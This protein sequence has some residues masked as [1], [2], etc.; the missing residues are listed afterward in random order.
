MLQFA[1][2]LA[3]GTV[4]LAIGSANTIYQLPPLVLL[5]PACLYLIGIQAETGAV[6]F[7]KGLIAGMAAF[8]ACLYWIA[9]PFAE[10]TSMPTYLAVSGP[11]GVSFAL[12]F[13]SAA[14]S[15]FCNKFLRNAPP[16]YV[17]MSTFFIWGA[18]ELARGILLSGF[19]W[20]SLA[21]AFSEWPAFV[22]PVSVLGAEGYSAL[23]VALACYITAAM[24][25]SSVKHSVAA[26]VSLALLFTASYC[27]WIQPAD[28][29]AN[30][31]I[32][33]VQG[34]INQG[35]KWDKRFVRGTVERYVTL[36]EKVFDHPVDLV[37]WPETSMPFY[38]QSHPDYLP[39][40]RRL[41]IASKAPYLIGTPG[42]AKGTEGRK[43]DIFNR[44]Y[45]ID[46]EGLMLSWYDKMHLVPFGEYVPFYIPF[47][48]ELLRGTGTF[49]RGTVY[50]PITTGNLAMGVL[51]C[52]EAI[53]TEL[54]QDRVESGAN[55][56]I[57]L[58]NDAW[59][60]K[61]AAPKQHLDMTVLRAVEQGRY[62]AR[63]T[64]TG[65]T[66]II[67]PK[68]N[69]TTKGKSFRADVIF[70]FVGTRTDFTFYHRFF[71]LIR[72]LIVAGAIAVLAYSIY[73]NKKKEI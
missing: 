10:Q 37:I 13:Y 73:T 59:F 49:E 32:A 28:A 60:G 54:A 25:A 24:I 34:N 48:E 52:Y 63:A 27:S 68:G 46:S 30:I 29:T 42:Y 65:I 36:S 35:A 69:I 20:A 66:A 23:L 61:T 64:N 38:L 7:R 53:F 31:E 16:L 50:E 15:W 17:G 21:A 9:V 2:L 72:A 58:S 5:F 1:P 11:L 71:S 41:A 6:A 45:L 8:T 19:S 43:Y 40:I 57:N 47:T 3:M 56:L 12:G 22:Q 18:L 26:L 67:D 51:I 62:V 4:G 55:I 39:I 14:F 44:A 70:G 33:M